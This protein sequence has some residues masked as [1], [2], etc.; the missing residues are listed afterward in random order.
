MPTT[1]I[2]EDGSVV[3]NANAFVSLETANTYHTLRGNATWTGT[4]AAKEAAI[5][6]ATFYLDRLRWKGLKTGVDNPLAWPRYGENTE[7][8]NGIVSPDSP[9]VGVIDEDGYNVGTSTVPMKVKDACC[10]MALRFLTGADPEP[11]LD[12]GGRIKMLQVDVLRTEYESGAPAA[13]TYTVVDRLL[14]GLL[15]SSSTNVLQLG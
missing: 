11:D 13:P 3:A 4:D 1:L 10:E 9:Y 2:V 8:W 12:R 14:R 15:R 6:K 7:G 5:I